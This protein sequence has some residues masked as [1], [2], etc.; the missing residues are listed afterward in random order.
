MKEGIVNAFNKLAVDYEHTVDVESV[1]NTHYERPAMLKQLPDDLTGLSVLDAGC[2]AGW[3]T[4]Q[5]LNRGA[6][7]TS[8]DVSPNMVEATKRRVG[9]AANVLCVDMNEQL[10]FVENAFDI[11]ISS[12]TLHYLEDWQKIFSKLKRIL[13]TDGTLLYSVQHPFIDFEFSKVEGKT[14]G[15]Y[16]TELVVFPWNKRKA[17]RVEVPFYRRP[18][19]KMI[20]DT[21]QFFVIEKF[22][23]PQPIAELKELDPVR[24]EKLMTTPSFL[25][26]KCTNK[27]KST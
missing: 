17:G 7:V 14:K 2:A 16:E 18:L 25:I 22:I 12:L 5:L 9:T 1:Y 4:E 8:I 10:P 15:Y 21:S 13:K 3:Y 27:E 11:I 20:G 24:Y 6:T 26:M 19:H 23:E